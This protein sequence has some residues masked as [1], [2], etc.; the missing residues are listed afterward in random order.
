[1]RYEEL[2]RKQPQ[3]PDFPAALGAI[4]LRQ[5]NRDEA[6]RLW[7]QAL[8][9][10]VTDANL[11]YRYALLAQDAEL[12]T[13]QV[14]AAFDRA[15]Q[16]APDFDD[17]RYKL[18]L[19]E[20][21]I[22]EDKSAVEQLRA[23]RVPEGDRR[24][25]YWTLMTTALTELDQRNEAKQAAQEAEKAAKTEADRMKARQLAYI[26]ATDL[27]V[28]FATDAEGHSHMVTTR[29]PHG[30]TE[31]NPFIEPSD[32]IRHV[33]GKLG[34]VSCVAGTLSG[35]VLRT[36]DGQLLVEVPDPMHVLMRNSPEEFFCGPT[37]ERAVEADYAVVKTAGKTTNVL[38]GLT[39][40]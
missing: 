11:C 24:Y 22:G 16:L 17:A 4:A 5:G 21:Q 18:A 26:A 14:K 38:R 34:E 10:K 25:G 23:M 28:Q 29:V 33:T 35:F 2:S 1:M 15:V 19:L 9:N 20:H 12:D 27:T 7:Q 40:Q 39:F 31:W 36:S 3:N 30:T 6:L 37:Q 32:E 13:Q 8:I